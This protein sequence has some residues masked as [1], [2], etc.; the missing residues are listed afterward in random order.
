MSKAYIERINVYGFKSYGNRRLSIPV[1]NG[2]VGIVG[3]NGSGKSNI[4]DAIV[5]AL[6]LATAKSMRALKLSDL[7]FSSRGRSA[8]YAEVEVIFKNEG[9]F[10]F[11]DEYISIYRKVEHNGKSTYKINGRPVK[12][13]DV[14]EILSYAGIPKQGYNIVTQGDIFKFI[15]MTP[16][17]RRELLSEI[18]G[19]TEY[20]ERKEKALKDLE[21]TEE[22]ISSAKLVLKEVKANL[23]RLEEERENALIASRLEEKIAQI[24]EKIKGVKLYFLLT[25]QEKALKD[26]EEVEN[27]INKLYTDKEKSIEKQKEKI[28]QI[29]DLE[30]SLNE[31]QESLLPIKEKEGSITSQIRHLNEKKSEIEKEIEELKQLLKELSVEKENHIK[32]VLN[33]EEEIKELKK[34]LPLIKRELEEAERELEEKNKKL[35]EIEIGGSKAK[36]DLGEVEKEEKELKEK[37]GYLHREKLHLEMELSRIIEKIDSYKEEINQLTS[38]LEGLRNSKSNIKSFVDSQEKKIKSLQSELQRLKIRKDTL[39]K[40]LKENREKIEANFQRLAQVLAQLSQVRED[41]VVSLIK[42]IK[43]VYGQVADLIGV[44]NPDFAVAI[45]SAGGGR[46]KN[47]VVED[48]RVAQECIRVLKENRAGRAT[49]IPLNRVRVQMPNKPPLMRGVLGLAV[50]FVD[51]DKSIEKAVRYVFG[52]TVIVQDFDSARNLGIGTYR[53]VTLDGE[54]FEKSGTITGGAEKNRTGV[55]GKGT[56]EQE[57][58][59]LEKEDDRLKAEEKAIEEELKRLEEK[60]SLTQ[61]EL[62]QLQNESQNV[63]ERNKEIEEKINHNISRI[64]ILDEE[65]I[66]LKKKQFEIENKLENVE[67]HLTEVERQITLVH[68]R[69]QEILKKMESEGLHKLRK[70]WEEVTQRVYSLRE[71]KNEIQTQIDKLTDRLENNIKV[72]IFQIENEKIKTEDMLRNRSARIDEAKEQIEQ[73]SKQLSDLW[74]GLKE[75]EKERDRLIEKI[76]NL[77]E[78]LKVLRYE[79]ENINKEITYLLEDKGKYEQKIEDL[80]EELMILREEYSGEPVEGDLRQLEK[81]LKEYQEKRQSIGAVNQKAVEDYEEIKARFDDLS[82]KLK[83]LVE[84]KRSIEELIE[85]LEE[86]KIKA[87]ME[88]FEAVNKNL[89]KIFRRLSPGGKAYLEIENEEDPLSGGILLKARPRGKDVKRLEI[90]SGGEKTLTALAFLFAV[91]QYR[92]APFYYFDEVDAHLDDSNARKIAELMKEL[93]QE[94]QFIVVTLRDT[95]ASYADRLLGVSAREGISSVYTLEMAEVL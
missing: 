87:F 75:K 82:Q 30:N 5:F 37:Q 53:M 95:M 91:Q 68:K 22:K 67:K 24:Q 6:G 1:G 3:P 49:F 70:E 9:A 11:N 17:E 73:L 65:I 54:I 16:S 14:E 8:E 93:S 33:I 47:I 89:G 12:Q 39:L 42:D 44:K 41:R 32:E 31:I 18:A 92:P 51:Y 46:L 29:K 57:K 45:E 81:D 13:Y 2:F 21:E 20:E 63:L 61:K 79:E 26:L 27:R 10:P 59:R 4:G 25:E 80:K 34:K 62:F 28:A 83:I 40:K 77:K 56:L 78:E 15:K 35:K 86:K 58:I 69:K 74:K 88:V 19:I 7:I 36:L 71:Q 55:L 66:N 52:D 23:K 72:R 64:N 48:D 38:E 94:A 90:M 84:E 60:I 50:D 43:G 76:E 85:N